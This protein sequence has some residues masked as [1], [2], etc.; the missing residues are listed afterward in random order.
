MKIVIEIPEAQY[1]NL[2]KIVNEGKEPLGYWERVVMRGTPLP[3][4]HGDLI[5][6][7]ELKMYGSWQMQIIPEGNGKYV[8][9]KIYTQRAVDAM[10]TI[11]PA[12]DKE[13]S[14]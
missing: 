10:P 9:T 3:K 4:G 8:E 12:A 11:I 1:E 14:K 2:A 13:E 7:N 6:R 5:D